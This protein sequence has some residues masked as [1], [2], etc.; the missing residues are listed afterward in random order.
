MHVRA[1]VACTYACAC[2]C[3]CMHTYMCVCVIFVC[4]AL[5]ISTMKEV[6]SCSTCGLVVS[7]EAMQ[8]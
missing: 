3:A 5:H 1:C 8:Q 6:L 4:R 7:G 2:V